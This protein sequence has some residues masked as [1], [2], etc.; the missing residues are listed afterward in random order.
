MARVDQG[1][2]RVG[3]VDVFD[4]DIVSIKGGY[5]QNADARFGQWSG[6]RK[7]DPD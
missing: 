1:F 4:Q 7:H 2:Y 5:S 3:E 6:H